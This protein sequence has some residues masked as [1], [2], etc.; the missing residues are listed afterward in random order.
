MLLHGSTDEDLKI[1]KAVDEAVKIIA[2]RSLIN[3]LRMEAMGLVPRR[4]DR[5]STGGVEEMEN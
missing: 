5:E 1:R 3:R 2:D 4:E